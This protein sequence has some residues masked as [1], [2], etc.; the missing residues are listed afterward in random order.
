MH[1]LNVSLLGLMALWSED[2][3]ELGLGLGFPG[4]FARVHF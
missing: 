2:L 4:I 3:W 1:G